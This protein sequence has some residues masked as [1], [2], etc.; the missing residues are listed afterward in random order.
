MSSVNV[1]RRH[2]P[3]FLH[4]VSSDKNCAHIEVFQTTIFNSFTAGYKKAGAFTVE[5]I[6]FL[7][8]YGLQRYL[9]RLPRTVSVY[10]YQ[11]RTTLFCFLFNARHCKIINAHAVGQANTLVFD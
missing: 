9:L 8:C 6:C 4:S 10:G 7:S 11:L 3:V 2:S 1:Y 5:S